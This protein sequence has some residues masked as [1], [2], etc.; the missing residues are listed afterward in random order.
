M[1]KKSD[2]KKKQTRAEYQQRVLDRH[3]N[4]AHHFL[5][6]NNA[7]ESALKAGYSEKSA[8]SMGSR[9]LTNRNVQ[10]ILSEMRKELEAKCRKSREDWIEELENLAFS[11]MSDVATWG[12]GYVHV[13]PTEKIPDHAKAAVADI[14]E[15]SSTIITK[16]GSEITR[17]KV[18][19]KMH[20]KLSA[21]IK[22]GVARGFMKPD[23]QDTANNGAGGQALIVIP[24]KMDLL[25]WQEMANQMLNGPTL[26]QNN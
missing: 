20:D 15:Q 22:Y 23:G 26:A 9:L 10:K 7:T 8:R 12:P 14:T 21:L 19:V 3:H 16:D 5:E 6:T 2:K 25:E 4:F 24:G 11:R 13:L 1:M 18:S 17:S